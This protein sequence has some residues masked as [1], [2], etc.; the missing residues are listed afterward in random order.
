M[1]YL[2]QRGQMVDKTGTVD[3]A[4]IIQ[5]A[6]KG[7]LTMK[8]IETENFINTSDNRLVDNSIKNSPIKN[9]N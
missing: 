5:L 3:T 8:Q 6:V 1:I 2:K 9:G 7:S 4:M